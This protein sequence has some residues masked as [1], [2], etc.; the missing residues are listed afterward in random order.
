MPI[1][2]I[3]LQAVP[4]LAA[5]IPLVTINICY[6][7]AVVVEHVPACIPYISGCTSV[8]STGRMAP[9]SL[10]FRAGML[11]TAA[12]LML[13]WHRCA[14]FLELGG[15]ATAKP[16]ALRLFG[17]IA[18]LSLMIYA[19]TLGFKDGVYPQI[20]QA[21][22]YGFA[23]GT[24]FAEVLFIFGSRPICIATSKKIWRWL[25]VLSVALPLLG[26]LSELA[27]LAGEPRRA[28]NNTV[29]WN[30]FLVASVFYVV[31]ARFW[32]HH[33]FTGELRVGTRDGSNNKL[34]INR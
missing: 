29:A 12:V 8:S 10:I 26:L 22:I 28:V 15:Q 3:N 6:L 5:V 33:G 9:E 7:V 25:V 4:L 30:A 34:E 27:K 21:G 18:A 23:F 14:T 1:R 32:Q 2:A 31:V 24:F 11:P 20:R 16:L 17:V 19:L 13:F